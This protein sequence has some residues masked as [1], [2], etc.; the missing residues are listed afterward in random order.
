MSLRARFAASG[1][2]APRPAPR[3]GQG[4]RYSPWG[5]GRLVGY[6]VRLRARGCGGL[7][8]LHLA[9]KSGQSVAVTGPKCDSLCDHWPVLVRL[10][11]SFWVL[12]DLPPAPVGPAG[13]SRG[14]AR[15]PALGAP[16]P[17]ASPS[18]LHPAASCCPPA[19]LPLS[20][21]VK[22]KTSGP[23]GPALTLCGLFLRGGLDK[24]EHS[25]YIIPARPVP[26]LR[27]LLHLEYPWTARNRL[28][29]WLSGFFMRSA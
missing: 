22:A 1:P 11:W 2:G 20:A 3:R 10:P 23:L 9:R 29:E 27:G 4:P 12:P 28:V 15:P 17:R 21:E 6:G 18:P 24:P 19:A 26:L 25:C 14:G 13:A 8:A 16:A 7:G 5:A